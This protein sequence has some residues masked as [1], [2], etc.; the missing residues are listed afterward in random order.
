MR[1]ILYACVVLLALAP[2]WVRADTDPDLMREDGV[3]YFDDNLPSRISTVVKKPTTIYLHRDFQ[4]ILAGIDPGAKLELIGMSPEGYLVRGTY[5]NNTVTGWIQPTDLP[6]GIDPALFA[7]AKKNQARHDKVA[8]AIAKKRVI[9]GMSPDEVR[10]SVGR[11][12]Q[13]SSHTDDTGTTL[14]W[15]YT[16]YAIQYQTSYAPGFYNHVQLQ[17]YPVKVP[18]GQLIINFSNGAVV[19]IEEHKTDPNSPGVVTN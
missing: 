9:R 7:D 16:T 12:E 15:V 4:S 8:A 13:T 11:P 10:Q 5:R 14:T 17:S 19:S 6:P 3:L 1:K 2:A 18:V